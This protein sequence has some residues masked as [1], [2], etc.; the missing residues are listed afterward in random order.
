[1][2]CNVVEMGGMLSNKFKRYIYTE[3]NKIT[4]KLKDFNYKDVYAT[5]Y[6]YETRNQDTSN[7]IAPLYIDMDI[8]NIEENFD[9]IVFDLKLVVN[10]LKTMFGISNSDIQFFFSG[11]KGFHLLIDHKI[12]GIEP[13]FDLNEKYKVIATE[14]KTYTVTKCIDTKIYDRKRLFRVVN[15]VN[16]KTGLY[17]VPISYDLLINMKSFEDLKE[18]ASQKHY[19]VKKLYRTKKKCAERFETVVAKAKEKEKKL[20][21]N[22]AMKSYI[23][24]R[25]LLPCVEYLLLNGATQGNRNNLT[26]ALASSLLQS[27]RNGD[28]V[29][30]IILAWNAAKNDPRLSDQE[31]TT[32][33]N[34]AI[35]NFEAKRIYGCGSFKDMDMCLKTCPIHK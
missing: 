17:K 6:K 19:S 25:K 27:G 33:V 35:K 22:R 31:V 32:T 11:S 4:A 5:I 16:S 29:M 28:E 15:T 7:I 10:Q 34:S 23:Q 12:L 13:C 3:V 30:E 1:M 2:I 21:D 26:I 24:Q 8:D 18:F 14:L 20:I 9:A